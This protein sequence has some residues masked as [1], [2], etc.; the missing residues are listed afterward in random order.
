MFERLVESLKKFEE[1]FKKIGASVSEFSKKARQ[2][3]DEQWTIIQRELED[4]YKLIVDHLKSLPG[5]D[6]MKE[7]YNEVSNSWCMF[8]KKCKQPIGRH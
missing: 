1:D 2:I 3:I 8:T 4:V 5:L 6:A 7:K